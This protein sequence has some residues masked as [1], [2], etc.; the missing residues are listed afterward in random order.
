MLI[1]PLSLQGAAA[2]EP[3]KILRA[4]LLSAAV[5]CLALGKP[6]SAQI[7]GQGSITGTVT[8]P[9]GAVVPNA[10]VTATNNATNEKTTQNSSS[11]GVFTLS[12]LNPGTYT[13]TFSA[14]GFKTLT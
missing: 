8:D 9:S 14:P 7:G 1:L 5:L 10:T 12:P 13:V 6:L 11:S 4:A 2:R 3:F